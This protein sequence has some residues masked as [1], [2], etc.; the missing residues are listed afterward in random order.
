MIV[1][2]QVEARG[3][4]MARARARVGA[5]GKAAGRVFG[6]VRTGRASKAATYRPGRQYKQLTKQARQAADSGDFSSALDVLKR[7]ERQ[8]TRRGPAGLVDGVRRARAHNKVSKRL[9]EH[10]QKL[11]VEGSHGVG[12]VWA[13]LKQADKTRG[14]SGLINRMLRRSHKK[15]V[16]KMERGLVTAAA[17]ASKRGQHAVA[18]KYLGLSRTMKAHRG[19]RVLGVKHR[20][21]R[22]NARRRLVAALEK[23]R[24]LKEA[25]LNIKLM[26]AYKNSFRSDSFCK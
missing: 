9:A 23:P 3:E 19:G 7:L 16:K 21:V 20:M 5:F 18:H 8:Q 12:K 1:P 13:Q 26:R 17:Q 6:K 10:G 24:T 14:S 2:Q 4:L 25:R 22:F 15:R 11:A